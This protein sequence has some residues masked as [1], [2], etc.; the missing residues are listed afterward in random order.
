MNRRLF[1]ANEVLAFVVELLALAALAY[2]GLE[3]AGVAL[4]LA[5]PVIAVILW[6]LFAAPRARF[7]IP[8]AG[9]VMVKALV[10]GASV[11][12]LVTTGHQTLAAAFGAVVL[13]NT[14]AATVWRSRG[15]EFGK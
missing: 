1:M 5:L 10:F 12:G 14:V 8:L 7:R 13:V 15:F 3:I 2:T 11:W 9:Q 6:G 4:A